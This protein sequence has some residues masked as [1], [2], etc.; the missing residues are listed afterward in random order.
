MRELQARNAELLK[1]LEMEDTGKV[2]DSN[3]KKPN[4]EAALQRAVVALAKEKALVAAVED[5][6]A[7]DAD[8]RAKLHATQAELDKFKAEA[9]VVHGARGFYG[10][11]LD[12]ASKVKGT[13]QEPI[14]LRQANAALVGQL[15]DA[16]RLLEQ[17][18]QDIEKLRAKVWAHVVCSG[19]M[20]LFQRLAGLRNNADKQGLLDGQLA[21]AESKLGRLEA[22]L[23]EARANQP[24]SQ[25][26][27]TAEAQVATLAAANGALERELLDMNS[28]ME[29][30]GVE[31]AELEGQAKRANASVVALQQSLDTSKAKDPS[32]LPK[33]AQSS[34]ELLKVSWCSDVHLCS[35]HPRRR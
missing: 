28:K 5:E 1:K 2:V 22:D 24:V 33:F 10:H 7:A 16:H 29:F 25:R 21:I 15:E 32:G 3:D 6:L 9:S 4:T 12:E 17:A 30:L 14:V 20:H 8:L 18:R 23:A 26:A 27:A 13:A 35:C 11:I 31:K 34:E 19:L